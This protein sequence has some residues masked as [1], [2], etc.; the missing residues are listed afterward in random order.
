M[1]TTPF[2]SGMLGLMRASVVWRFG[3]VFVATSAAAWASGCSDDPDPVAPSADGGV[4][5][6][7]LDSSPGPSP[8]SSV[9][10]SP[11]GRDCSQDKDAGDN[12]A[13]HLECTGLYASFAE[14]RVAADV[15]PFKPGFELWSDGAEKQRWAY[16]PPGSK[17][18]TTSFDEWVYPVGTKFW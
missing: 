16:L 14:K 1:A 2:D 15:K 3:F 9:D 17:I 4:E 13:E 18:D 5:A 7:A 10:A 8:D 6:A 12:L 11:P